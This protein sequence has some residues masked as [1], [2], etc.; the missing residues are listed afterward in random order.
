MMTSSSPK[1]MYW[2]GVREGVP[3]LAIAFSFAIAFS[4]IAVESGLTVAQT[5]SLSFLVIAGA[6][7]FA[8]VQ[9]MTE[10]APAVTVVIA[11]LAVNLR[12]AMYS[13]SM[14]P[15]LGPAP[16]WQRVILSYINIDHAYAMS[17]AEYE[18][19]PNSPIAEKVAYFFGLITPVAP[20]WYI[21]SVV[22]ALVGTSMPAGLSLEFVVPIA[23]ISIVALMLRTKA[24]WLAAGVSVAVALALHSLPYGMGLLI[25]G[26]AAMVV[27]ALADA[28]LE[29]RA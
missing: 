21:G 20:A 11:A 24:H 5:L 26:L 15:H 4:V 25:A 9:L 19:R 10:G 18:A 23:F 13:A 2:R 28:W 1:T 12:M 8:A 17:M 7:Q 3:F 6:S 14:V 16:M 27:G 29:G 22:G